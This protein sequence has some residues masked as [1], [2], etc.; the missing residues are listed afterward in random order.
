M[1]NVVFVFTYFRACEQSQSSISTRVV[2]TE[3][4]DGTGSAKE[5]A[6]A[7]SRVS[8]FS[9]LYIRA[10]TFTGPFEERRTGL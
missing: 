3:K 9:T 1:Y 2:D 7:S 4:V 8:R 6:N 10:S 5:V